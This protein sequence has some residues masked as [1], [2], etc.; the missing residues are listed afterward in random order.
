LTKSTL[1]IPKEEARLNLRKKINNQAMA[2]NIKA[3]RRNVCS[4]KLICPSVKPTMTSRKAY[5]PLLEKLPNTILL[6]PTGTGKTL[7]FPITL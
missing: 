2:N 5:W 4:Q 3:N 1:S 6:S 7:A